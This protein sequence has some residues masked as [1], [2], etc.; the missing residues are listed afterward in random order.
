MVEPA[1]I[2]AAVKKL[3][4]H[5]TGELPSDIHGRTRSSGG[6][7]SRARS[8]TSMEDLPHSVVYIGRMTGTRLHSALCL[9]QAERNHTRQCKRKPII[10]SQRR[11]RLLCRRASRVFSLNSHQP[12]AKANQPPTGR[13]GRGQ[14]IY[15]ENVTK[16]LN[17]PKTSMIPTVTGVKPLSKEDGPKTREERK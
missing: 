14:P 16:R 3:A 17:V 2:P 12:F 9:L 4:D 10:L 8:G 15:A 7:D 6:V 5:F 1:T 11:R 13:I